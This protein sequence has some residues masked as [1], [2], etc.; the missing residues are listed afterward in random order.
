M[1]LNENV[2]KTDGNDRPKRSKENKIVRILRSITIEPMTILI[3]LHTNMISIPQD[4]ML[5]YKTCIQP[6]YNLR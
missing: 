2:T 6:K 4:Q 3:S 1:E 5:L